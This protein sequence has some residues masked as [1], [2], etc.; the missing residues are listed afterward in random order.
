MENNQ[1]SA[2]ETHK[3]QRW[4]RAALLWTIVAAVLVLTFSL[5]YRILFSSVEIGTPATETA[6]LTRANERLLEMVKWTI[7]TILLIG[8]ALIGLNW[9]SS[10]QR[11]RTDRANDE[12]R[13]LG[14]EFSIGRMQED[15]AVDLQTL[16]NELLK[17]KLETLVPLGQLRSSLDDFAHASLMTKMKQAAEGGNHNYIDI[18]CGLFKDITTTR[19]E[20]RLI[21]SML[22]SDLEQSAG[23]F[24][25]WEQFI[26]LDQTMRLVKLLRSQQ[27]PD[28]ADDLQKAFEARM[29]TAS[30]GDSQ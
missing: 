14:L 19:A 15:H 21:L 22:K 18:Y 8:G 5:L 3:I 26:G 7:S 11:Y 16:R 25:S 4:A 6:A 9:Y 17:F 28:E 24:S 1:Q 13:I 27:L 20:K 30:D 23:S 10:E 2:E 12:R 29:N